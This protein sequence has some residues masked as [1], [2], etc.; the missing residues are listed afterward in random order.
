MIEDIVTEI[1]SDLASLLERIASRSQTAVDATNDRRSLARAGARLREWVRTRRT[2]AG[3]ESDSTRSTDD[4][5][6]VRA[7][8]R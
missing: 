6:G 1:V 3:G 4:D 5:E 8:E 2:R 7:S